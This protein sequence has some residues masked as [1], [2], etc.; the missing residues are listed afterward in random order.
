MYTSH[1]LG[2]TP[3]VFAEV[4]WYDTAPPSTDPEDPA[5]LPQIVRNPNSNFNLRNRWIFLVDAE[6]KN[7]VFA[8]HNPFDASCTVLDVIGHNL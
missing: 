7:Y 5:F 8:K 3:N 2:D 1:F 4:E 6:P